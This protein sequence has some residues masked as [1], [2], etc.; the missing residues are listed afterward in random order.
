MA[1]VYNNFQ[2]YKCKSNLARTFGALSPAAPSLGG[3][4]K[5]SDNLNNRALHLSNLSQVQ[6][7]VLTVQWQSI[8]ASAVGSF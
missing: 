2:I 5:M 6:G 7:V 1:T 3:Y 8:A 4:F